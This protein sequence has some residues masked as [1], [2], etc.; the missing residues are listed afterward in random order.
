MEHVPLLLLSDSPSAS[1]GLGRICRDLATR[2]HADMPE[3]EIAVAGYGGFGSSKFGWKE[4]HLSVNENWLYPELPMVWEDFAGDRKGV[5]MSIGDLSRFWW[6][7]HTGVAPHVRQ[8]IANPKMKKWIYH[9]VDAEGPNGKLSLR[10]AETMKCFDR[11]LDYS[12][13]SCRVTGNTEHLPHGIDTSVFKPHDRLAAKR[14]FRELGFSNLAADSFLV[15]IVATNQARKDWALA[16]ETCRILLDRGLDV[17][18]WCHTDAVERFWSLPNLISDFGL[19]DRVCITNARF[20]DEQMAGFY[21]AC[22]VTLSI[23]LGEGFGFSTYESLACGTPVVTGDYCGSEW[24]KRDAG[25]YLAEPIA[26]RY[27]GIYACK[28]PVYDPREWDNGAR[29]V[30]GQA[31]CLPPE[32][33]WDNLWPRWKSWLLEGV[34]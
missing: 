26:Y 11:V 20:T 27:E 15:G 7:N 24:I 6:M 3:F 4:Y 30:N 28:R 13:F 17:K 5:W 34:K 22:D 12:E 29:R 32:L 2:I 14:K 33:D 31:A 16:F 23:G 9:P 10:L 21:S 18:M 1:S 25:G 19:Q 8:W